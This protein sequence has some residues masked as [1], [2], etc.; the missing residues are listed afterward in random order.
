MPSKQRRGRDEERVP[1]G[2]R[3][4]AAGGRQE[5]LIDGLDDRSRRPTAEDRQLVSQYQD[6]HISRIIRVNAQDQQLEGEPKREIA[7]R[8]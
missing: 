6:F 5:E 1:A 2:A 8:E 7:E 3:D 4:Q